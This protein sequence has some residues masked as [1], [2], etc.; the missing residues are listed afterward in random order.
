MENSSES[1]TQCWAIAQSL[2][3]AGRQQVQTQRN[4]LKTTV[5]E[6]EIVRTTSYEGVSIK[7][8]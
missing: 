7:L 3:E 5:S 6:L 2:V 8:T 1:E 4:G